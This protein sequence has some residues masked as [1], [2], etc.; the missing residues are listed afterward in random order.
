[1][2]TKATGFNINNAINVRHMLAEDQPQEE[3]KETPKRKTTPLKVGE[4]STERKAPAPANKYNVV[5]KG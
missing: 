2:I 1:M 3:D 4:T 5:K